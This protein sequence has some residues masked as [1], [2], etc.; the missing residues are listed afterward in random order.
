[1]DNLYMRIRRGGAGGYVIATGFSGSICILSYVTPWPT[2]RKT[3]LYHHIYHKYTLQ[4]KKTKK[5]HA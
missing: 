4:K 2:V 1:M 3:K 5:R